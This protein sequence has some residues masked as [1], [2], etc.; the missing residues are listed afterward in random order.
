MS[1]EAWCLHP[2]VHSDAEEAELGFAEGGS[3]PFDQWNRSDHIHSRCRP[4]PAGALDCADPRRPCEGPARSAISRGTRNAGRGG[5]GGSQAEPLEIWSEETE[6][7][8]GGRL[9]GFAES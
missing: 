4:Q 5:R 8:V 7:I 1:A 3:C 2:C 9:G 6:I